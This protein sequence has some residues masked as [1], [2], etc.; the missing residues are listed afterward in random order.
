MEAKLLPS[1][2]SALLVEE[3]LKVLP[4][5]WGPWGPQ[6]GGASWAGIQAPP[7]PTARA[8]GGREEPYQSGRPPPHLLLTE[9]WGARP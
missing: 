2:S 4:A 1:F 5:P 7:Q 9:R 8:G 3:A 6:A